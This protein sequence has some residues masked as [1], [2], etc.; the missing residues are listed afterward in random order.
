MKERATVSITLATGMRQEQRKPVESQALPSR[1]RCKHVEQRN[2]R[3]E[4]KAGLSKS[5]RPPN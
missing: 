4:E 3:L 2:E 5:P 1:T